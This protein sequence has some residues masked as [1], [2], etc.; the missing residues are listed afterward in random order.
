[1]AEAQ[2]R[3]ALSIGEGNWSVFMA[4]PISATLLACVALVLLTPR[5]LAWHRRA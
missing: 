3:N 1:M 4:R 5:L 2:L